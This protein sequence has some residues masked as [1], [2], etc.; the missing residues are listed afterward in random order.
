MLTIDCRNGTIAETA[1]I[2]AV[3]LW[4]VIFL[5]VSCRPELFH[6]LVVLVEIRLSHRLGDLL[7]GHRYDGEKEKTRTFAR[8]AGGGVGDEQFRFLFF[9]EEKQRSHE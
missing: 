6:P 8:K 4:V 9:S 1:H 3:P 7:S 2:V 5:S